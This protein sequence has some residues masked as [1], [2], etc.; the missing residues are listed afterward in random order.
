M[1]VEYW[2]WLQQVLGYSHESVSRVLANYDTAKQFYLAPDEEKIKVC[3]LNKTQISRLHSIPKKLVY[4][5]MKDA[6][7]NGID[8]I[9][10]EDKQYPERLL[11]IPDFPAVLYCKGN[12]FEINDTPVI[13]IVGPRKISDYGV[14]CAY[15]IANTLAS[16]GFTVVSGCALGGDSAAHKG[17]IDAGGKTI[18]VLGC[19]IENGYLKVNSELKNNISK[20]GALISE[21]PPFC[22][23]LKGAFPRRNR[24][25]S[26]LSNGVVV[27]EGSQKS[28]TMI[29]AKYAVEQG[30]DLFVIPGS[31]SLE[32]YQGS[33][34]LIADGAMPLLNI[35]DIINEYVF[36]YPEKIHLPKEKNNVDERV[37]DIK[38]ANL[39]II[40]KKIESK[41]TDSTEKRKIAPPDKAILSNEAVIVLK[42][43]E[44]FGDSFVTD[45]AVDNTGLSV[46]EVL[47][48]VT[49]LEICGFIEAIVGGRYRLK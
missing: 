16:C 35:N 42:C 43:F 7:D 24:I 9:T 1:S 47:S 38:K 13:T 3:R 49:E 27:I 39:P 23:V 15:V 40:E 31:P 33:N 11:N 4:K 20:N 26:A 48:A 6:H 46:S 34:R 8:I 22:N 29:T 19:G 45:D 21:Y 18:G 37:N 44:Q 10:P 2:I 5:I 28:G 41:S 32:Q 30:K 36:L 17:A 25:L 12:H 14:K